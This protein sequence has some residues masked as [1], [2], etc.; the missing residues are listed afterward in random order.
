LIIGIERVKKQARVQFICGE[1]V[2]RYARSAN[3]ELQAISQTISAPPLEAA[4]A[5]RTLWNELQVSRKQIEE[6]EARVMDYEA[7]EF[8][9]NGGI[10]VGAFDSRGINRLKMLATRICSR[11]AT[12]ALLADQSD[13]LRVV[14]ARS[15]DVDV[16]VAALLKEVLQRFGGRGGGRGHLAQGGGLSGSAAEVLQFAEARCRSGL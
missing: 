4:A 15:A 10:A 14:F 2:L 8:P 3:R 12:T 5:V 13:Q 11:P 16:D 7:A 6:F 9:I 1:R